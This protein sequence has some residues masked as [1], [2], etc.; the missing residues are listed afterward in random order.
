MATGH[1]GRRK[2]GTTEGGWGHSHQQARKALAPFVES[3]RARCSRCGL[4]IMPGT[5]WHLDHSD[6]RRSY[7]GAAH[8]LCNTQAGG[9]K[10]NA[11]RR[12]T[13]LTPTDMAVEWARQHEADQARLER[14]RHRE[15]RI[16]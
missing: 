8:A 6:D 10:G 15:P 3:G 12:R 4:P 14:E 5:P 2:V 11:M 9:R 7:L 1:D 13:R 16:Y